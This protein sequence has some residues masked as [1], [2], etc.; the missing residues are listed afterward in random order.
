MSALLEDFFTQH[1]LDKLG[2]QTCHDALFGK[3][4]GSFLLIEAEYLF[5]VHHEPELF[6]PFFGVDLALFHPRHFFVIQDALYLT[7]L[8]ENDM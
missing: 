2:L 7:V 4:L 8:S 6:A 3:L 1:F 5:S